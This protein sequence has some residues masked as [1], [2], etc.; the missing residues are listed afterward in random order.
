M[1]R[2]KAGKTL[3]VPSAEKVAAI[4]QEDAVRELNCRRPTGAPIGRN[5]PLQ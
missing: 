5:W 2:L 1:N 4:S 3:D